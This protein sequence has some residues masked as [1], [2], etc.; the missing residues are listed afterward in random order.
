[1]FIHCPTEKKSPAWEGCLQPVNK[2][3]LNVIVCFSALSSHPRACY[4]LVPVTRIIKLAEQVGDW[5]GGASRKESRN[6]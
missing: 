3:V 1:M 6:E 5:R 2:L 4:N